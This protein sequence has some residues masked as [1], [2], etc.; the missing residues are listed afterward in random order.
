MNNKIKR[1]IILLCLLV[2]G[3]TL[4]G[5]D[6]EFPLIQSMSHFPYS[7]NQALGKRAYTLSLNMFYSNIYV[8]DY[9]RTTINDME[10]WSNTLAFRY[11]VSDRV[12]VE[13]YYRMVLAYEGVMDKF[14]EDFHKLFGLKVGGR[15]DLPRNKVNY[16]YKDAFSYEKGVFVQSPLV[17]GVL[18]NLYKTETFR[19]NGR[20]A[21]GL[22][23]FSKPGFSSSKPFYTAGVIFLYKNKNGKFSIDFSNHLSL[24]ANPKWLA[25][26]EIRNHIF[27]SELRVNYKNLFGGI[28]YRST[29]F[30]MGDLSNGAYQVYIGFRFLKRFEFSLVEEFPPMDTTPDVTFNLK[31]QL[32]KK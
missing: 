15:L 28:L 32:L 16:L 25:D 22:P 31:I 8:F 5:G 18:G 7:D 17:L 23:I 21:V 12:T 20:V 19:I 11:G 29:P 4:H 3:F 13:L 10:M 6:V 2:V 24:F 26:E 14:I 27:L 1:N 30:K 9:E